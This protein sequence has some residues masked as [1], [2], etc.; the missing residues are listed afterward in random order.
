MGAFAKA[1]RWAAAAEF[2]SIAQECSDEASVSLHDTAATATLRGQS[3]ER[4]L[5]MAGDLRR[6]VLEPAARSY[7]CAAS[8]ATR[9]R[10]WELALTLAFDEAAGSPGGDDAAS[11]ASSAVMACN[12]AM[13]ASSAALGNAAAW[14]TALDAVHTLFLRRLQ[15]SLVTYTGVVEVCARCSASSHVLGIL[16][17]ICASRMQLDTIVFNS[18]LSELSRGGHTGVARNVLAFMESSRCD[19][20][21]VTLTTLSD[22]P[23]LGSGSAG[24]GWDGGEDSPQASLLLETR[25]QAL[26]PD[27]IA[28]ETTVGAVGRSGRWEEALTSLHHI[29]I[30]A[31]PTTMMGVS[32]AIVPLAGGKQWS[33]VLELVLR[34]RAAREQVDAVALG[35]MLNALE[36]DR[37]WAEALLLLDLMSA[38]AVARRVYG[39]RH[40]RGQRVLVRA[41]QSG[42][43]AACAGRL[44]GCRARCVSAGHHRVQLR[45]QFVRESFAVGG[46]SGNAA[47]CAVE[48]AR[49]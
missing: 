45:R 4:A 40:P 34:R 21:V 46:S 25:R 49:P 16:N 8:S 18:A 3:W 33:R 28:F 7:V 47:A 15:P 27:L 32:A 44:R 13:K 29:A 23:T 24:Y 26:E 22:V 6:Q 39:A 1:S 31:L 10:R 36:R 30:A 48:E 43:L 37:R 12:V 41:R 35:G 42:S 14:T 20:D 19:P 5:R 9:G 38:E 11:A 2:L 17:D